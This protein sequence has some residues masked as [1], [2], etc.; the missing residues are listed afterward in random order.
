MTRHWINRG[1]FMALAPRTSCW[2]IYLSPTILLVSDNRIICFFEPWVQPVLG[3]QY[4]SYNDC[5]L[6]LGLKKLH[7]C[8]CNIDVQTYHRY[9]KKPCMT[10]VNYPSFRISAY[11]LQYDSVHLSCKP[12]L[13]GL[14]WCDQQPHVCYI[15]TVPEI[16]EA[17]WIQTPYLLNLHTFHT[18]YRQSS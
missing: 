18:W 13:L 16:S 12:F 9:G 6:Q 5:V 7:S 4:K 3:V 8:W 15:I 10:N 11:R 17:V 1:D 2:K 14:W